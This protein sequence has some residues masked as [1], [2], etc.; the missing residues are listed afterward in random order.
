[1]SEFDRE[2]DTSRFDTEDLEVISKESL[3]CQELE[4][5]LDESI[6]AGFT[7]DE[8]DITS[9][10]S[11]TPRIKKEKDKKKK[12][13]NSG[14]EKTQEVAAQGVDTAKEASV[15]ENA[16]VSTVKEEATQPKETGEAM[17]NLRQETHSCVG[18]PGSENLV[19]EH[20]T[21]QDNAPGNESLVES[22]KTATTVVDYYSGLLA[23]SGQDLTPEVP[24]TIEGEPA[25]SAEEPHAV[26]GENNEGERIKKMAK[27]I[28]RRYMWRGIAVGSL[29]LGLGCLFLARRLQDDMRSR[30]KWRR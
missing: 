19:K 3:T 11:S 2:N 24:K 14:S 16:P 28:A 1:M 27:L 10:C 4:E 6:K 13:T 21:N 9:M 20:D 25:E 22:V 8:D 12:E 26:V 23:E 29:I 7:A 30:R 15:G 5:Y 17:S 18:G